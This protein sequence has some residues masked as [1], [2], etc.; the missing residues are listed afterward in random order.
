MMFIG[1]KFWYED[2]VLGPSDLLIS[3]MNLCV[4]RRIRA[5]AFLDPRRKLYSDLDGDGNMF[6]GN[7]DFS[8]SNPTPTLN[9]VI[10]VNSSST[11]NSL[12]QRIRELAIWM[13]NG[14]WDV[15]NDGDGVPDSV[16][17]DFD[18]PTQVVGNGTI[19]KP[20]V[21]ALIEDLD[22]RININ[23]A[24][25]YAQITSRRFQASNPTSYSNDV[26]YLTALASLQTFGRGGGVGPAEINF[27]HLFDEYRPTDAGNTT[28]P[29]YIDQTSNP[30]AAVLSTRYGNLMQSRYGGTPW[31]YATTYDY[32]SNPIAYPGS[33]P[34]IDYSDPFSR[35]L[36]PSRRDNHGPLSPMG[37]SV[38]LFGRSTTRKLTGGN[39]IIDAVGADVPAATP[40]AGERMTELSNQ[41]YE[42][43]V[44]NPVGD[45][46]PFTAAEFYSLVNQGSAT[47]LGSRLTELL[48][49]AVNSNPALSRLLT[50]ESRSIDNP[51]CPVARRWPNSWW[52]GCQWESVPM[53]RWSINK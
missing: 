48:G 10:A 42:F 29:L 32:A 9:E 24:G 2:C 26:T 7:P 22:G 44:D 45:D 14:P 39:A 46:R 53:R 21:A 20:L 34:L 23:A 8:G 37:R 36:L 18:L 17:V 47:A 50:V 52:I 11:F 43:E 51:N 15:D 1:C 38:D 3:I 4:F 16:W 19:V 40:T 35:I 13:C 41:P 30:F 6:D 28:P 33:S 25:N 12:K 5:L 27:S 31:G 49:D